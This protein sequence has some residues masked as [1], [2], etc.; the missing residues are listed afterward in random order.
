VLIDH[1]FRVHLTMPAT[2]VA[3]ARRPAGAILQ[4]VNG[5]LVICRSRRPNKSLSMD[6]CFG[7]NWCDVNDSVSD[8]RVENARLT[9]LFGK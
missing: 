8:D 5:Y 6:C 3:T 1:G 9:A 2:P 4:K 7:Y